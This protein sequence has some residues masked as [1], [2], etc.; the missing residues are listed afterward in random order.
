MV[1]IITNQ[2][3]GLLWLSFSSDTWKSFIF[4]HIK[5]FIYECV[6]IFHSLFGVEQILMNLILAQ[7]IYEAVG[8]FECSRSLYMLQLCN[9]A[10]SYFKLGFVFE[11]YSKY[12]CYSNQIACAWMKRIILYHYLNWI[13]C[14]CFALYHL[15][16][17]IDNVN[18]AH[19]HRIIANTNIKPI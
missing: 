5:Y 11:H 18:I 10:K 1:M 12:R 2:P 17:C 3:T 15:L 4:T 14:F 19:I 7:I 13:M 16:Y 9:T 6:Y 8:W